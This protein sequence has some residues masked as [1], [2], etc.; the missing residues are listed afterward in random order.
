[1]VEPVGVRLF[2]LANFSLGA[3]VPRDGAA[4][5]DRQVLVR[6]SVQ[7]EVD[8]LVRMHH[9]ID[10]VRVHGVA[11]GSYCPRLVVDG[12]GAGDGVFLRDQVGVLPA[13]EDGRAPSEEGD[14]K[15]CAAEEESAFEPLTR[16][17][18]R[19]PGGYR[20]GQAT[21]RRRLRDHMRLQ[22][23]TGLR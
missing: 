6:V 20:P 14:D 15:E 13:I 3:S 8:L 22:S 7:V 1:D 9:E 19:R 21:G 4:V 2:W 17:R 11:G 23:R 16:A 18:R 10:F 12:D 5:G